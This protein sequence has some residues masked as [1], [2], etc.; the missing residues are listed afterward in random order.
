MK[1]PAPAISLRITRREGTR[2]S[3]LSAARAEFRLRGVDK[4]AMEE[5]AGAA[6]VSRATVYL[7]FPGKPALLEALLEED[8][9]G[10]V[11]LF[12]RLGEIDLGDP[13]RLEGW[14]MRV[15]EG[16]RRARDSFGIH[17]AALGQNP[18]LTIRH[19][20]HRER[21]ARVLA[22]TA[23][24]DVPDPAANLAGAVEAEL[25]V[26]ELEH[27]ATAAA[28]GWSDAQVS[29]ALPLIVRRLS[30]FAERQRESR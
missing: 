1:A 25:I 7:H 22:R 2:R 3:L 17:W 16:M 11:R 27:F 19:H 23:G 9:E 18:E 15:A 13:G 20:E 10:Q 4:V 30:D 26:A 12:E 6:G 14:V 24:R 28:I 21:L 5:I 29:L 8:W